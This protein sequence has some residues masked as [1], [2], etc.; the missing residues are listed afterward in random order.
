MVRTYCLRAGDVKCL[1]HVDWIYMVEI[2]TC[3]GPCECDSLASG[4]MKV[5]EF[6]DNLSAL[7]GTQEGLCPHRVS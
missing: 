4:F 3:V 5:A 1:Q 6:A 2:G 7:Q